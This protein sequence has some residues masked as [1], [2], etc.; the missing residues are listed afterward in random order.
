MYETTIS[1]WQIHAWTT[2]SKRGIYDHLFKQTAADK[3]LPLAS[4]II[5]IKTAYPSDLVP[6]SAD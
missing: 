6:T 4:S 1:F 5:P 2:Y 3:H